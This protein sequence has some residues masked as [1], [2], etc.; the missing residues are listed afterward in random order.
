[1]LGPL[2]VNL[3]GIF[4]A[5]G[6][7]AGVWMLRFTAPPSGL[8]VKFARDLAFWVIL[9]GLIGSRAAYVLFHLGSFSGRPWRILDVWSGG[10]MF[11][12]GLAGGLAALVLALKGRRTPLLSAGDALAPALSLGQAAGRAGCFFEGCCYGRAA[13]PGFPFAVVFPPGGGAPPG[14]ELY[15]VQA[16]EGIGL[17]VLTFVLVRLR[18]KRG[19]PRGLVLGAYLLGAGVLRLAME[20]FFRGDFRGRPF[21]GLPPT[22]WAAAATAACGAAVLALALGRRGMPRYPGKVSDSDTKGGENGGGGEEAGAG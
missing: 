5:L 2:A 21:M 6:A 16:M 19:G 13:P 8:D 4:T 7:A 9:W 22:S 11:Q 1:V 18:V 12:G 15:P 3:Y 17:L 14:R 20:L 10:L